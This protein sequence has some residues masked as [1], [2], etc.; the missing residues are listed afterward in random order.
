[1]LFSFALLGTISEK[2]TLGLGR[3]RKFASR[4]FFFWLWQGECHYG[5]EDQNNGN[6]VNHS[7]SESFEHVYT[8]GK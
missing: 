5:S 2:V 8:K 6:N 1:M 4:R 3:I 7:G